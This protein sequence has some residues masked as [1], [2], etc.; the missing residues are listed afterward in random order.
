[1]S[2]RSLVRVFFDV[3]LV[4]VATLVAH[5]LLENLEIDWERLFDILPYVSAT[6][7][8]ALGGSSICRLSQCIW[9]SAFAND[10]FRVVAL[11]LIV[12]CSAVLVC[13]AFN[14]LE[15]VARS[16]PILQG[17]LAVV[18]LIGARELPRLVR[19]QR[20]SRKTRPQ[21][22]AQLEKDAPQVVLIVGVTPLTEV[23]LN[24]FETFAAEKV[25]VAGVLGGN[26]RDVDCLL[27]DHQV[28]GQAEE[29]ALILRELATHGIVVDRVIVT[30]MFGNLTA[31]SK[32]AL[33]K[34]ASSL[35]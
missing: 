4:L 13:F 10:Y 35:N 8:A 14:R 6:G 18:A 19:A 32:D 23:Y 24:L 17:V 9:N 7:L 30:E 20:R 28:L 27:R 12:V 25:L 5:L 1:M 15:G 34:I 33:G 2:V 16:L 3:G 21:Q 29:I 31:A 11:V 26:K 22:F